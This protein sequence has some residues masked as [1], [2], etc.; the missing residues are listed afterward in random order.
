MD[1]LARATTEQLDEWREAARLP[2]DAECAKD[3]LQALPMNES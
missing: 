3:P 2:A 1:H